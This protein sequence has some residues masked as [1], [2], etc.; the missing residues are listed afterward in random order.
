M[1]RKDIFIIVVAVLFTFGSLNAMDMQRV[2]ELAELIK[3]GKSVPAATKAAVQK[4]QPV[5]QKSIEVVEEASSKPDNSVLSSESISDVSLGL[6]KTN[7]FSEED[8]AADRTEYISSAPGTSQKI[9]RAFENAPPMIPHSVKD[10]LPITKNNNACLGCHMPNVAEAAKATPI[11]PSHF[12]NFRPMT[13]LGASGEVL[14]EGLAISNT[15]DIK[16]VARKL[17]KLYPGR[18]N[19][20]QC[21]APQSKQ[22]AIVKNNFQPD[23]RSQD[24]QEKSNLID[25]INEGVE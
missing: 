17:D 3:A 4:S 7:L 19:C 18:Y 1:L 5:V 9:K 23:F 8:T 12:T 11:P 13:E 20:S 14:K 24:A 25:T 10:L 22:D 15:S 6:R 2:N 16:I 21:H